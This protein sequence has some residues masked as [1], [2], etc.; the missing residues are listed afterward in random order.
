[1]A[2]KHEG[3]GGEVNGET[4]EEDR[5]WRTFNRVCRESMKERLLRDILVDLT[6]CE[7]EGWDK[8][9]YLDELKKLIYSFKKKIKQNNHQMVMELQIDDHP[10]S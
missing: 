6:V 5:T 9:E 7:L 1:M 4:P 8:F 3:D 10:L 2:G